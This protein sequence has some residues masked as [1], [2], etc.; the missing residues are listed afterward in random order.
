MEG[1]ER[2]TRREQV[3]M[4]TQPETGVQW[5]VYWSA[6]EVGALSSRLSAPGQARRVAA[7]AWTAHVRLQDKDASGGKNAALP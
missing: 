7:H 3:V 1:L 4:V 2:E 6:I 5:A